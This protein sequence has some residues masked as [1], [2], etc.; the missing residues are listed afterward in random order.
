[1]WRRRA[2]WLARNVALR[3]SRFAGVRVGRREQAPEDAAGKWRAVVLVVCRDGVARA[4]DRRIDRSPLTP[5]GTVQ[6]SQEA[7]KGRRAETIGTLR[8]SALSCKP[9]EP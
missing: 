1:M 4:V 8:S 2:H 9:A 5:A 3:R 6:I 7:A